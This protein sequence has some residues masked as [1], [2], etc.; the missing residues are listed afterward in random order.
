M[1]L[2]TVLATGEVVELHCT[3]DPAT[4]GG[5]APNGRKV[6]GT[7][8]WVSAAHALDAE[9]R[10]YDHLF[11]IPEPE[12]VPEGTDWKSNL[13]AESLVVLSGCKLEPSLAMA[14]PGVS[15]QFERQGYF[16]LDRDARPGAP[17]FNRSVSLRDTWAK[18][19]KAQQGGKGKKK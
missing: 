10:L 9:V 15:Y 1:A 14:A 17:V 16:C 7:I 5:N 6:K 11:R 3:Y 12:D 18:I 4:K 13:N 19:E 8:H 2:R